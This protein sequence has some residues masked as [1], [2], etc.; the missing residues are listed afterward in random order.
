VLQVEAE[1]DPQFAEILAS[2][3]KFMRSYKKW[4]AL[5]YLPRDFD[6]VPEE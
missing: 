5:A 1:K 6:E 2:Q 3:R 4:K